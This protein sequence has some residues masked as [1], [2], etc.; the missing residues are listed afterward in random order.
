MRAGGV[1]S[2]D[3]NVSSLEQSFSSFSLPRSFLSV[4]P[5]ASS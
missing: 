3:G 1:L 4:Y 2:D 5:W